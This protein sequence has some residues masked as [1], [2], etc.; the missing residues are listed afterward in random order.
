MLV[1]PHEYG[2][3]RRAS[4]GRDAKSQT[5]LPI[6]MLSKSGVLVIDSFASVVGAVFVLVATLHY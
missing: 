4:K 1:T 3:F 2:L 6:G 5:F